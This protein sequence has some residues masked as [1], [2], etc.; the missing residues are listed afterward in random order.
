MVL[1]FHGH[2][3]AEDRLAQTF[4][5]VPLLGTLP[6]NVVSGLDEMGYH[7]LWFESATV[8]RLAAILDHG[9]PVITLLRASDLP[10]GTAGLHAVVVIALEDDEITLLDPTL[11]RVTLMSQSDFVQSWA[12]LDQQGIVIWL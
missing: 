11:D 10:H 6:E 7:A 5:T 2:H 8:A 4:H 9:W 1:A 12:N 3:H